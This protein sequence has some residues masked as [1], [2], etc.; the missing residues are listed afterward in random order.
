MK[1][2][3][4][5]HGPAGS[6]ERFEEQVTE[7]TRKLLAFLIER[8]AAGKPVAGYGAPAK[9]N[10]LLNYCGFAADFIDYTVD[11]SPHK[12]AVSAGHPHSGASAGATSAE[13]GRI[14]C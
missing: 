9:G 3:L 4:A 5:L 11:R 13:T 1:R 7:T 8:R 12:Q 14:T 2:G 10:T 6:Y